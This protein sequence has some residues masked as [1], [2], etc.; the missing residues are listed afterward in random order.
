MA[1]EKAQASAPAVEP[2]KRLTTKDI[3]GAALKKPEA[4]T[5]LYAIIGTATDTQA[6]QS[7]FGDALNYSL[8]GT[9]EAV[10]VS[11]GK[12]FQAPVAYIPE[13]ALSIILAGLKKAQAQSADASVDFG[14]IVCIKPSEKSPVGY[15]LIAENPIPPKRS[16]ALEQL[17]AQV[18]NAVPQLA[19]P[20][21]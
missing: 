11:D 5:R 16:D 2:L 14:F 15:E 8:I 9:F 3:M 7:K 20:A 6:K 17:R 19:A 12:R 13:P 21:K 1:N 4:L 10:R 18:L